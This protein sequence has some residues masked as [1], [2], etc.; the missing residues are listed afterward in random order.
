[1][2]T[3]DTPHQSPVQSNQFDTLWPPNMALKAASAGTRKVQ[4]DTISMFLLGILAGIFIALA[5]NVFTIT[6]TGSA[7]LPVGAARLLGGMTF[8]LGLILVVI[9]G[10]EL[11]T[12]N[13][14]IVMAVLCRRV[15]FRFLLRS[16][17]VV[18][19]GNFIGSVLVAGMV[20]GGRA[21]RTGRRG[22]RRAGRSHRRGQ[23]C[24]SV[25]AGL[26]AGRAVQYARLLGDLDVL[27]RQDRHR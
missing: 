24:P 20:W 13:T 19:V 22:H 10:A 3:S 7:A 6:M 14:L 2:S 27:R 1:M 15:A 26:L 11:F 18:Y 23:V 16:W 9:A 21:G 5:S 4:M 25:L 12:G 17:L 8:S